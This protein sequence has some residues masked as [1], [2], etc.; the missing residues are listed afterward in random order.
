[1][2]VASAAIPVVEVGAFAC[3]VVIVG[4][5]LLAGNLQAVI[6]IANSTSTTQVKNTRLII[7]ASL[8]PDAKY[9]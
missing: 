7:V 2:T 1:V 4:G 3:W 6:P 8:N 5:G 9:Q